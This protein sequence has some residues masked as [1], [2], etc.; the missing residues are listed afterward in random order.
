MLSPESSTWLQWHHPNC[1]RIT[2]LFPLCGNQH[3]S[4]APRL[5]PWLLN[6]KEPLHFS[7]DFLLLSLSSDVRWHRIMR[8]YRI[9]SWYRVTSRSW[10]HPFVPTAKMNPLLSGTRTVFSQNLGLPPSLFTPGAVWEAKVLDLGQ[11]LLNNNQNISVI[12]TWF[13]S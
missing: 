1:S 9:I 13:S 8:W 7:R 11:A 6:P 2:Q 5:L 12:S 3:Y 10:P 4:T